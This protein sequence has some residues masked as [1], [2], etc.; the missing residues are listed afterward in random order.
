VDPQGILRIFGGSNF[1]EGTTALRILAIGQGVNVSVG[2]A[3]FV[4][5]MA[6]RTGWDLAV[7]VT[8]VALDFILALLLVP[9]FGING[10]AAAQ[11]ITIALSNWFRLSLVRRFVGI[12]PWDG[13]YARLLVPAGGCA[14][15]MTVIRALT[16]GAVWYVQLVA[17]GVAGVIAYAPLLLRFGLVDSERVAVRNGIA[18]LRAR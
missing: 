15:S 9:K 4:L 12:F 6:G 1:A 18:K 17:I 16:G 3:G 14:I 7:Y 5:I 11:A 10:A 13:T 2:A 8:S